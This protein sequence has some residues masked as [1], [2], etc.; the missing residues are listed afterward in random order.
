MTRDRS[1]FHDREPS[2]RTTVTARLARGE[3]E[4]LDYLVE[5]GG[6]SRSDAIR[7][8]IVGQ[9]RAVQQLNRIR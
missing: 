7:Q 2:H 3:L 4:M 8:A 5:S 9:F 6:L 1:K